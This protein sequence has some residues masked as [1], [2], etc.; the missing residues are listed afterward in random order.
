MKWIHKW[1][2]AGAAA[3]TLVAVSGAPASALPYCG[4]TWSNYARCTFEAPA[5][6]FVIQGTATTGTDD[7]LQVSVRVFV[8]V[9]GV[10]YDVGSCTSRG[11]PAHCEQVV[12]TPFDGRTHVCEVYGPGSAGTY[13][14]ADPPP[15]P[16]G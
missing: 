15:L 8:E 3:M 11:N 7:V 5:G 16:L 9:A 1:S 10:Q 14:C 2:V 4:G 13:L 6:A 12:D